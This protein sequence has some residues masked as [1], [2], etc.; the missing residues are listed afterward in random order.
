LLA[1]KPEAK[2]PQKP[3]GRPAEKKP[4]APAAA[5]APAPSKHKGKEIRGIVRVAGR[6]LKGELPLPR[7]LARVKGVGER[8]SRILS[9]I[10]LSEL[11]IPETTLVGE[12]SDEQVERI[13]EIISHPT[14]YGVPGYMV[15]RQKD[16]ES[17]S[18]LHLIG[19]DLTFSVKQDIE[20]DKNLNTWRGYRHAYGQKV[21]GQHTR[22]TGRTGMT[23][24]VLRKAVLAAKAAAAAPAGAAQAAA[25]PAAKKEEKKEGKK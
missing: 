14:K 4:G 17:G 18:H 21:R 2:P 9:E 15:N 10:A 19:T 6:D 11:R 1:E 13:E 22:S 5:P 25:P 12:L 7:A 16:F 20:R 8:L 24:G 3:V 23:V